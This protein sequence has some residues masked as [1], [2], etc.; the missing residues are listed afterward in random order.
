MENKLKIKSI[1]ARK[2]L[3]DLLDASILSDEEKEIVFLHYVKKKPLDWIADTLG[4]SYAK[5]RRRHYQAITS[6]ADMLS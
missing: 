5:I 2:E 6:L 4:I 1:N 3:N